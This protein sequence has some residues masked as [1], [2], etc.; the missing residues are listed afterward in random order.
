MP[1][2]SDKFLQTISEAVYSSNLNGKAITAAVSGGP[3]S[4]AM[5]HALHRTAALTR[6]RL[7]VVH[8]DHGIREE[9]SKSDAA[10]VKNFCN[11]IGIPCEVGS[12]DIPRIAKSRK[13]S[14][15]DAARR[16]RHKF[17]ASTSSKFGSS[18]VALGH[19]SDDQ[20]ETVLMHVMRGS[21]LNGLKG[22]ELISTR[23]ME[24]TTLNLFRPLLSISRIAVE[25]YCAKA[26]LTPRIDST[27]LSAEF[28]RNSVRLELLPLMERYNP[29]VRQA[30]IR[31][32][33]SASRDLVFL[34][35]ATSKAWKAS[36]KVSNGVIT[37]NTDSLLA[38]PEAL[39][40]RVLKRAAVTIMGTTN[41]LLMEHVES[42]M[43]LSR[44][45]AG[46]SL[47]L[48]SGATVVTGYGELVISESGSNSIPLPALPLKTL[49]AVP[50]ITEIP[51]WKIETS[52]E[53][54]PNTYPETRKT[55]GGSAWLNIGATNS[56]LVR[57]RKP[58]DYFHP[59]GMQDRKKLQDFMV[60]SKIPRAWRDRIPLLETERG[61]AWVVGWRIAQWATPR[62]N[63][64]PV[65]V[66]FDRTTM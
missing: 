4:L 15:E 18:A 5:V 48:P 53:E 28:T 32:S 27:N 10:F 24:G 51:G 3:D 33:R 12:V 2:S 40:Y 25:S 41:N 29:A 42:M 52:F 58:G 56:L 20:V 31:L 23:I 44:R 6:I 8:L 63:K 64:L 59:S 17:L 57:C 19:T 30:L 45:P 55:L 47:D 38:L 43:R 35:Q 21:G 11:R 1:E 62:P 37:I 49:L 22:M 7:T 36:C 66:T 34:E 50:G 46:R 14:I 65:K 13:L 60:D 9:D 26:R 39:A 54:S 16:E 61:V